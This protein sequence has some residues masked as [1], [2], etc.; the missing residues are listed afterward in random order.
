MAQPEARQ[1]KPQ[2][3]I[4]EHRIIEWDIKPRVAEW[5]ASSDQVI[6]VVGNMPDAQPKVKEANLLNRKIQDVSV[7]PEDLVKRRYVDDPQSWQAQHDAIDSKVR[8][9]IGDRD[10][11][12]ITVGLCS[13]SRGVDLEAYATILD[14]RKQRPDLTINV[15]S[16]LPVDKKSFRAESVVGSLKQEYWNGL[17]DQLLHDKQAVVHEPHFRPITP[18][19][20]LGVRRRVTADRA[21][22][23]SV[24]VNGDQKGS[25][26]YSD[27]QQELLKLTA[28][29]YRATPQI[30][31][32][33]RMLLV[34]DGGKANGDGGTNEM[35]ARF[36]REFDTEIEG[37]RGQGLE[38]V[39]II[40]QG[41]ILDNGR[42]L[43]SPLEDDDEAGI[44]PNYRA[45]VQAGYG[46]KFWLEGFDTDAYL[47]DTLKRRRKERRAEKRKKSQQK[48][49]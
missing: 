29:A 37:R 22:E 34:T 9:W 32:D 35:V 38:T 13:G 43:L 47:A 39:C 19:E 44:N 16:I 14:I 21:H 4:T 17:F 49:S 31:K 27:T 25:R 48:S 11:G 3:F 30:K 42:P 33:L 45:F 46:N 6:L 10:K 12:S 15:V 26:M 23:R 36:F 18:L 7:S 2:E 20:H 28:E 1:S 41:M 24:F 40:Q 8:E 5:L